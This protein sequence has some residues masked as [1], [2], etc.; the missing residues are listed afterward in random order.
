MPSSTLRR[1][2]ASALLLVIWLTGC[3]EWS[4][5]SVSPQVLVEKKR[6]KEVRVIT[7]AEDTLEIE[8]PTVA[9]DSLRGE[10]RLFGVP[11]SDDGNIRPV[12]LPLDDVREIATKD[13]DLI[14]IPGILGAVLILAV[15]G[16]VAAGGALQ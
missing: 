2:V 9:D 7:T 5:Q 11:L 16:K 10:V 12:S 8:H 4:A 3:V 14:I 6:P 13:S 1:P 15:A